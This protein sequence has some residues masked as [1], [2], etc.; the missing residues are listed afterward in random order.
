[1]SFLS[2]LGF[3]NDSL[4]QALRDG[5][6]VI[7]V[8]TAHEFDQGKIKGSINIPLDRLPSNMNRIRE[9]KKPIIVCCT[10]GEGSRKATNIL[11]AAGI[12]HVHNGGSWVRVLRLVKSEG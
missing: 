3:G 2:I 11:K 8:R 9:I 7:D 1:M 12:K 4:K 5:A 6:V 10:G